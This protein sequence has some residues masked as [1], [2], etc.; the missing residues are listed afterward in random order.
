MLHSGETVDTETSNEIN[1]HGQTTPR[2]T[3]AVDDPSLLRASEVQG[4]YQIPP[5]PA[6]MSC[7]QELHAVAFTR[8]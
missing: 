7:G 6:E 4:L 1:T 2:T 3:L 5:H 8:S